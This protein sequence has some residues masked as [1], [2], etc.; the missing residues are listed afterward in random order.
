[1]KRDRYH[2]M[3]MGLLQT[4]EEKVNVLGFEDAKPYLSKIM[5][6][7]ADLEYFWNSS[8]GGFFE[9][10]WADIFQIKMDGWAKDTA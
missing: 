7:V 3:M 6:M 1:M 8:G 10:D 2:E 4:A 5:N 9:E